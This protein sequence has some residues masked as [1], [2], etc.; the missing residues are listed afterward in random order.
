MALGLGLVFLGY[1]LA[2][3]GVKGVNPWQSFLD[4]FGHSD[5]VLP[6]PG[7]A[8]ASDY[9][10]GTGPGSNNPGTGATGN[11]RGGRTG[12]G[13]LPPSG[14]SVTGTAPTRAFTAAVKLRFPS[15]IFDGIYSCR[16]IIPHGGGT[17]NEWSQHS[18]GN[19]VD[20]TGSAQLMTQIVNFAQANISKYSIANVIPPGS[21]VNAVHVDFNPPGVGT[22]PCAGGP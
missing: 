10:V 19:A 15:A 20:F 17:S 6:R 1:L 12:G 18:W 9:S 16:K 21:A 11:P 13:T 2:Y 7:E 3:S 22:P 4:A 14:A 8:I 5:V